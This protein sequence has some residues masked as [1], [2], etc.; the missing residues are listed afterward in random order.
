[1]FASSPHGY[2]S[3]SSITYLEETGA[4]VSKYLSSRPNLR[5]SRLDLKHN[6]SEYPHPYL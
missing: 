3:L 5:N 2:G 1:M 4:V 6:D